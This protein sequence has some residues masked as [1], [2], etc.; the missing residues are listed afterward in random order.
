M[1]VN[2]A[3]AIVVAMVVMQLGGMLLHKGG[4]G[5]GKHRDYDKKMMM[6]DKMEA[7]E[8]EDA[9]AAAAQ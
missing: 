8:K 7:M 5:K 6:E 2:V 3:I 1:I 9:D 4:V